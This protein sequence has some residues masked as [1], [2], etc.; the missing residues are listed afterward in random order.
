MC[1]CV[2]ESVFLSFRWGFS[3]WL[4]LCFDGMWNDSLSLFRSTGVCHLL[5]LL[6]LRCSW[7]KKMIPRFTYEYYILR[8]M[9]SVV[10]I[11]CVYGK[12]AY[13]KSR[14]YSYHSM[15]DGYANYMNELTQTHAHVGVRKIVGTNE[16]EMSHEILCISSIPFSL[17]LFRFLRSN[18]RVVNHVNRMQN[19]CDWGCVP[20]VHFPFDCATNEKNA[21]TVTMDWIRSIDISIR[22]IR[23][24]CIRILSINFLYG[25]DEQ[26]E[27]RRWGWMNKWIE[28]YIVSFYF[29]SLRI[30]HF[31]IVIYYSVFY[32]F[33][34]ASALIEHFFLS[35]LLVA[36]H[37]LMRAH[38]QS[39]AHLLWHIDIHCVYLSC[40]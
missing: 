29:L 7:N 6:L 13:E 17:S 12:Y 34:F 1:V 22:R 16:C 35:S 15:L 39:P 25:E 9:L 28:R 33:A 19:A 18:R 5:L 31:H 2:S 10:Q 32:F 27:C 3:C 38:T 40:G 4:S 30:A 11:T 8:Q 37:R 36:L 14:K 26:D 23:F 24:R 21:K 20:S